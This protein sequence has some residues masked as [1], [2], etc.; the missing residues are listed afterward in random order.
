MNGI[1]DL[2]GMHGFGR[3]EREEDEPVFHA[4]WERHVFALLNLTVAAGQYC[5]DELRHAIERMPPARYLG[6]SY[7][8]HWLHA[9]EDLLDAKGIVTRDELERRKHGLGPQAPAAGMRKVETTQ[10]LPA[11]QVAPAFRT[12]VSARADV[13]GPPRFRP[14]EVVVARNLHPTGH[15]RLP[16]FVRGRR[17]VVQLDHGGFVFADARAHGLGDH[18]QHL[19]SVRFAAREL[20]GDAGSERDAVY[21]DLWESHLELPGSA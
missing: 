21:L 8:E 1:H 5:V 13:A 20:W 11:S 4:D 17:G 6:T 18:P 15:T 3:V 12:G 16:R 14:G 7:Y 19:Y 2:G 9:A 10:A